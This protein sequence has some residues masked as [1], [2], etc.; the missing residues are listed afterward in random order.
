MRLL[1]FI[2]IDR[3]R[4]YRKKRYNDRILVKVVNRSILR[5]LRYMDR[6]SKG[7]KEEERRGVGRKEDA[8]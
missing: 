8:V 6:R 2:D 5:S 7:E 3:I 1:R 4:N